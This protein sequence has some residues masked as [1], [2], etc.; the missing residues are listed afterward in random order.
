MPASEMRDERNP[1]NDSGKQVFL[2][3]NASTGNEYNT[4]V[5]IWTA[6][7][8]GSRIAFK[9][10][11]NNHIDYLYNYGNKISKN[12]DIVEDCIQ[13]LFVDLWFKKAKL[14]IVINIKAYL[15]TSLRRRLIDL[16]KKSK[17]EVGIESLENAEVVLNNALAADILSEQKRTALLAALNNLSPQKKEAIFLRF[18]ND[19]SCKEV[20]EIMRINT[21]SVYN[22]ISSGLMVIKQKFKNS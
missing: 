13:D 16:L 5:E 7:K 14:S 9:I 19:L 10:I 21:Q 15:I 17:T 4:D 3:K 22:L 20:G 8:G 11:Y 2:T 6:F 1:I 12:G 18:F